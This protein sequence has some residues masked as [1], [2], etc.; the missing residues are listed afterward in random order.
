MVN[1]RP[2][3]PHVGNDFSTDLVPPY[4]WRGFGSRLQEFGF[5]VSVSMLLVALWRPR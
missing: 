1:Q 5:S 2:A 4:D 3:L